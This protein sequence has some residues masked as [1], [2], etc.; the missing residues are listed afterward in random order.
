[1]EMDPVIDDGYRSYQENI[2]FGHPIWEWGI[3]GITC[4]CMLTYII[5]MSLRARYP[6]LNVIHVGCKSL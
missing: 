1:M 2:P 3:V 6:M 5:C 4:F